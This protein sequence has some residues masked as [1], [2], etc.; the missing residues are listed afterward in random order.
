M[1]CGW[2]LYWVSLAGDRQAATPDSETLGQAA[3]LDGGGTEH[4]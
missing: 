3:R 4:A 1:R 2:G